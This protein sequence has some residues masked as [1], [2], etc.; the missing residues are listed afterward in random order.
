MRSMWWVWI[1]PLVGI[2]L[3]AGAVL[4]FRQAQRFHATAA[5]CIGE[6]VEYGEH[7]S[8]DSDGHTT[9]MYTPIV[10][11]VVADRT[12]DQSCPVSSSRRE[13]RLGQ[14]VKVLYDPAD[15]EKFSL[16]AP[17]QIYMAPGI[18]GFIGVI[19]LI[20]GFVVV[21]AFASPKTE[22]VDTPPE[23]LHDDRDSDSIVGN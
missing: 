12:Y 20:V 17:F 4:A 19:F 6:V 1:F 5:R 9:H 18:L 23:L 15:P 8:T 11:Y 21:G 7:D 10:R 13:Y 16:D 22:L 3:L 14:R 2:G